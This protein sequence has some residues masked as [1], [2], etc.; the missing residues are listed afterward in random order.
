MSADV[1]AALFNVVLFILAMVL[2]W[3]VVAIVSAVCVVI[4]LTMAA[5]S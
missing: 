1:T 2:G 3:Y 5:T 4:S